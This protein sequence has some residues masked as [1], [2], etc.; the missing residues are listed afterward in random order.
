LHHGEGV[1]KGGESREGKNGFREIP[2]R[3]KN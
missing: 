3:L 2:G 1:K